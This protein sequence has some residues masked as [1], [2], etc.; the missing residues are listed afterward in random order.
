MAANERGPVTVAVIVNEL[1][2]HR[3]NTADSHVLTIKAAD[4]LIHITHFG[5]FK[6]V[7]LDA[8]QCTLASELIA[9]QIKVG[10][11]AWHNIALDEVP[12][13]F[14]LIG[15]AARV[16]HQRMHQIITRLARDDTVRT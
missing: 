15:L 9:E 10:S 14:T 4:Q 6:A 5:L 12:R 8:G 7:M 2:Q 11:S 16:E 1:T 3:F 13:F